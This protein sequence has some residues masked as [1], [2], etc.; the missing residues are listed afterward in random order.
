[1]YLDNSGNED[2]SLP[3]YS[4]SGLTLN[5]RIRPAE[6]RRRAGGSKGGF[7]KEATVG[8]DLG[9]IFSARVAQSGWVY[10]AIAE[11]LGHP[12]AHR[13]YQLGFIPIAPFTATGR[14]ALKF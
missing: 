2:R 6:L 9:N 10:S 12:D 3:G 7:L 8:L 1:M 5:Y 13:Y 14:I 11:S 4:L